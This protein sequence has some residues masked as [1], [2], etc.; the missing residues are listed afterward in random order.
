MQKVTYLL[1]NSATGKHPCPL[2]VCGRN[3]THGRALWDPKYNAHVYRFSEEKWLG[4]IDRD[5]AEGGHRSLSKWIVRAEV[6]FDPSSEIGAMAL[7]LD[8]LRA[9]SD[10]LK[11]QLANSQ[12]RP[13]TS[14]DGEVAARLEYE[15]GKELAASGEPLPDGSSVA[16]TTGFNETRKPAEPAANDEESPGEENTSEVP[17]EFKSLDFRATRKIAQAEGVATKGITEKPALV[18]AIMAARQAKQAA[19]ATAPDSE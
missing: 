16:F 13:E 6:E 2:A 8:A 15:A 17:P 3:I 1:I 18:N 7:E 5:I 11:R 10:Q 9:E 19:A 14:T 12:A 4:G